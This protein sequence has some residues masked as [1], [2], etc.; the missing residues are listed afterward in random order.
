VS[1]HRGVHR[2]WVP[3][4]DDPADLARET[5]ATE[6]GQATITITYVELDEDLWTAVWQHGTR[7]RDAYGSLAQMI[8]WARKQ[9]ADIWFLFD[10]E[11]GDY[12]TV[13]PRTHG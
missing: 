10:I 12:V 7:H 4:V 2:S 11:A 5:P 9:P 1:Q 13:L 8:S 6:I 3:D